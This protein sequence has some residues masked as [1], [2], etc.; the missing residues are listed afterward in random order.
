MNFLNLEKITNNKKIVIPS[1]LVVN[2]C[3]VALAK[4]HQIC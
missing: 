2:S 1:G 4:Y 3:S